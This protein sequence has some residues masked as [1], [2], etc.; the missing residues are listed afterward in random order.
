MDNLAENI[1]IA[2]GYYKGHIDIP[3][4][5]WHHCKKW[6]VVEQLYDEEE[7]CLWVNEEEDCLWVNKEEEINKYTATEVNERGAFQKQ[8]KHVNIIRGYRSKEE[9]TIMVT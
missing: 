9:E 3:M 7:D 4:G 1:K 8:W 2:T 5:K 6:Q